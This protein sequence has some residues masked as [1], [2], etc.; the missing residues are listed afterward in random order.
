MPVFVTDKCRTLTR[1]ILLLK[2]Q[3][4]RRSY[5]LS[6]IIHVLHLNIN[7]LFLHHI[8]AWMQAPCNM[9]IVRVC[10]YNIH[11]IL[12]KYFDVLWLWWVYC[13][14]QCVYVVYIVG[15]GA[16]DVFGQACSGEHPT[17]D[18]PP[19]IWQILLEARSGVPT[20]PLLFSLSSAA[21]FCIFRWDCNVGGGPSERLKCNILQHIVL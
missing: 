20:L 14:Q 9:N 13:G 10:V 17:P 15:R 16:F 21:L 3:L 2:L 19:F 12:G 18:P 5:I 4:K 7:Q 1:H 6:T 11:C 8:I